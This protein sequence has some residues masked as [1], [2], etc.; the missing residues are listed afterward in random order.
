MTGLSDKQLLAARML[1]RTHTPEQAA[2]AI[3]VTSRTIRRWRDTVPGFKEAAD[4]ERDAV[5]EPDALS[6]LRELL[7]SDRED[8]RLR[9]A[10]ALLRT[11]DI[12]KEKQPILP[13]GSVLTFPEDEDADLFHESDLAPVA[14]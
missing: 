4:A 6:T 1:G 3:G 7:T 10:V 11:P 14:S 2:D 13:P 5:G 9:A 8:I 12:S